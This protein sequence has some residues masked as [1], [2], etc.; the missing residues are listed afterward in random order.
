MK[1]SVNQALDYYLGK[2]GGGRLNCAQAVLKA[3]E[4]KFAVDQDVVEMFALYG[5]GKTPEGFCGAFYAAKYL[6]EKNLFV[7]QLAELERQFMA[8]AG[9]VK[10]KEIRGAKLFSCL[11][12]V[13]KCAQFLE[14][15][16]LDPKSY[17][18]E[19]CGK[20]EV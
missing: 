11:D 7:S 12:C 9:S 10:C 15:I 19:E 20:T 1:M 8:E 6:S 16:N 18:N 13:K 5:G 3:F 2:G 14:T 17:Y 4:R